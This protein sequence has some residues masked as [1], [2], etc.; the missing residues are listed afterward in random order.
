MTNRRLIILARYWNDMD[1]LSA[2]LDQIEYWNADLIYLSEGSWDQK[3]EP[4][5]ADG[6][7]EF[8]EEYAK[9]KQNV[10]VI[11]NVRTNVNYRIN[12]ADTSN[13]VMKL[14]KCKSDDWMMIV[15]VDQFYSKQHIDKV[16]DIIEN[17]GS[18]FEYFNYKVCNFLYNIEEYDETYDNNQSR[19]PSKIVSNASWI[20]TNHLSV[21]GITY[22]RSNLVRRKVLEDVYAVHYEG[23]RSKNRLTLRYSVGD[24]KSF[25]EFNQGS[26]LKNLKVF[27]G[28]H[29]TFASKTIDKYF[30][31]LYRRKNV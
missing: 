5:S 18:T 15:D 21:N 11:D 17:E 31:K 6:T 3:I 2:S 13:L 23:M 14:S 8:L 25:W 19:L 29:S 24:R 27:S 1:F 4:R 12:Q 20:Q 10:F 22:D 16:K 7:R 9:D 28:E 26:R 30:E